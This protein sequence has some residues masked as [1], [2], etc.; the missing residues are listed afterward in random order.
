MN[1][2]SIALLIVALLMATTNSEADRVEILVDGSHGAATA[3]G[4]V[5]VVD[6]LLAIDA[7]TEVPG[8]C[9][10]RRRPRQ[11]RGDRHR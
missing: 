2:S 1:P 5:I 11:P 3:Q 10:C 6:G 7:G 9:V 8:T 4:A